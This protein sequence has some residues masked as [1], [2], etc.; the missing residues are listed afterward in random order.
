MRTSG[1]AHIAIVGINGSGKSSAYDKLMK[2]L[3]VDTS[4]VGVGGSVLVSNEK[5]KLAIPKELIHLRIR[6]AMSAVAH[7]FG[8]KFHCRPDALI[9][10][11]ERARMQDALAG[12]YQPELVIT[13]GSPLVTMLSAARRHDPAVFGEKE[14]SQ[15][16]R[17]LTKRSGLTLRE[18]FSYL[19]KIPELYIVRSLY[20]AR[21]QIPGKIIFLRA[22]PAVALL[23]VKAQQG[24]RQL[25]ETQ[26]SLE[27]LQDAYGFVLDILQ[28]EHGVRVYSIDT[29]AFTQEEV[30]A[31]CFPVIVPGEEAAELNI[32]AAAGPG[33][34]RD[35]RKLDKIEPEFRKYYDKARAYVVD[36]HEQAYKRAKAAV[37]AGGKWLVSA[38]GAGTFNSVL[39]GCCA[40]GVPE[41]D[42][43]LA[44]LRDGATDLLGRAFNVPDNLGLAV[45]L[46]CERIRNNRYLESDILE[47]ALTEESKKKKCHIVGFSAAGI[48][49]GIIGY[50]TGDRGP[51]FA[52]AP[53]AVLRHYWMKRADRKLRFHI[54]A[55]DRT[56]SS[57]EYS[58]ILVLNGD[59]GSHFP[60]A[61]GLSMDSGDFQVLLFKDAGLKMTYRQV[62]HASRGDLL[63]YRQEL[64]VEMFRTRHLKII[65]EHPGLYSL[66]LDG[67]S[68]QVTGEIIYSLYGKIKLIT[69]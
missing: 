64:G 30:V 55:E 14:S 31:E 4:V 49:G 41:E 19:R 3:A 24:E 46:I 33:A 18:S 23:R 58:A 7:L 1:P 60:V 62:V 32:I 50:L 13:D 63:K 57:E 12:A 43:R 47:V 29:T 61:R 37:V 48:L 5:G 17:Y 25:D 2:M 68:K 28:K 11:I 45:G 27:K 59:L 56:M 15:L 44:F 38:G 65:P 36:S 67:V 16:C 21:L 54:I 39:E 34:L 69:G 35:R 22:D 51:F 10:L 52:G 6:P 66:N 42:I 9:T 26:E 40:Y 20:H 53:L 8:K